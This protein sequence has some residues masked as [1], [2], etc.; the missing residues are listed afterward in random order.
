[1]M[2]EFV[3]RLPIL[4]P[5]NALQ[6]E[7]FI[8]I[9][10]VPENPIIK[11]YQFLL[12]K[13]GVKLI[14]TNTALKEIAKMAI[15]KSIGARGLRSIIEEVMLD[16]MFEIPDQ[17]DSIYK[18]LITKESIQTKKPVLIL[19]RQGRKIATKNTIAPS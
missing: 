1:M 2:P 4:C 13:D 3:G 16:I 7:D 15:A 9:L 19:K 18:C 8:H 5:L 11:E 6:E 17:K 10:T 12:R 14:F